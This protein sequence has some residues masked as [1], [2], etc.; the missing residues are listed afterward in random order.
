MQTDIN[1][2]LKDPVR[3]NNGPRCLSDHLSDVLNYLVLNYPDEPVQRLEEV[4]YA[5]KNQDTLAI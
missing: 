1:A 3:T 4:S 5:L 2:L